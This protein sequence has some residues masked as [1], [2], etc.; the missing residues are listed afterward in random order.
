MTVIERAIAFATYAHANVKRKGKDRPYILHPM[1]AMMIVDGL[2][3]DLEGRDEVLAAAV[4]HD[5][6]E[7][8]GVTKEELTLEFGQ[9]VADLVAAESEDKQPERKAEESWQARKQATVDHLGT[10]SK[11]AQAICLGDKLANLRELCRDH[12]AEGE[13]LWERFNQ[14]EPKKHEWYYGAILTV[15]EQT[16]G[17]IPQIREY[18]ELLKK[19]FGEV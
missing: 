12:E 1:E 9:R 4:L 5:V 11:E 6:M 10:L 15:L 7:D 19:T 3:V 8:A 13:K 16:F 2:P 17:E 18:R 14:K